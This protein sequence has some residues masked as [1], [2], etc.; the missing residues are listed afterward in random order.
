MTFKP[1]FDVLWVKNRFFVCTGRHFTERL[2]DKFA[3]LLSNQPFIKLK[4]L[5]V[6][7][8]VYDMKSNFPWVPPFLLF[9]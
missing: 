3:F 1:V 5:M 6:N 8:R 7:M 9:I 4:R 2:L